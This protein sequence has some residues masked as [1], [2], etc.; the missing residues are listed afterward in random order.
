MRQGLFGEGAGD[1]AVTV[2]GVD[3]HIG[4][5]GDFA[6]A[7]TEADQAGVADYFVV[8]LPDV[9]GE[10]RGGAFHGVAGPAQ[11]GFVAAGAAHLADV[12][13]AVTVH[14]FVEAQFNEVRHLRK[15]A[16]DV[17][18]AQVGVRLG[19]GGEGDGG[20]WGNYK[21]VVA[22]CLGEGIICAQVFIGAMLT[23]FRRGEP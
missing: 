19:A 10:R 13:L 2:F 7:V 3:G 6:P 1:A 21:R 18:R 11:P 23:L 4:E 12:V 15:V 9:A 8:R 17:E 5:H 22:V 16:Q 14:A 20:H